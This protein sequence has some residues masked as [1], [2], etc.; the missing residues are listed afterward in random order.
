MGNYLVVGGST[1]IGKALV[2]KLALAG[3]QVYATYNST[4]A[5]NESNVEYH[6][7]NVM[8]IEV[9]LSF[10]PEQLHGI[11]Y[12]PG[13][14]QLKPFH[15]FKEQDFIDDFRLQVTGAIKVI[16]GALPQLKAGT[17][18]SIVLFSTVAVQQGFSF[19]SQVSTSKGA[20]EGLTKALSA[21]FAPTIRVNA[22]APSLT[23]TPLAAKLLSNEQK[24]ESN[25][26]RNPLNRVGTADE[27]ADAAQ[28]LLT[29]KSSWV[30]GQILHIDGGMSTIKL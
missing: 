5:Q 27:I 21:E 8:D 12:C 20:I 24:R 10:L 11:A 3:H 17:P 2:K 1:G 29:E 4:P 30:T 16:Q 23:D 7:L 25:A 28:F 14:I 22:I 9:D 15:R 18:S 6:P 19:H 26:I 13:S